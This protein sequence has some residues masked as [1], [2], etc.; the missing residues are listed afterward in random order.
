VNRLS[1]ISFADSA[2]LL[3]V[4]SHAAR[5]DDPTEAIA[6]QPAAFVYFAGNVRTK[7]LASSIQDWRPRQSRTYSGW[8]EKCQRRYQ[9]AS[10]LVVR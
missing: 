6:R 10:A 5:H 9:H 3:A 8:S 1:Q 4:P 2:G 7:R